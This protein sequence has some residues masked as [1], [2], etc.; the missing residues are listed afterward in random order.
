VLLAAAS[1]ARAD[2]GP[3]WWIVQQNILQQ[4]AQQAAAAALARQQVS[5]AMQRQIDLQSI[6]LEAQANAFET[7][8][9]LNALQL[10][11]ALDG[12]I[13]DLRNIQQNQLLQILQVEINA[14]NYGKAKPKKAG[15]R[16]KVRP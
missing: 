10:R 13:Q 7:Q 16:T 3:V 6:T 12:Q 5:Q 9:T 8:H 4:Q 2:Q 1:A 14:A 11:S 15:A